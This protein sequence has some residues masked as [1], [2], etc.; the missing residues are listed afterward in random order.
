[1]IREVP[2]SEVCANIYVKFGQSGVFDFINTHYPDVSWKV[3]KPCD[4]ESPVD[5]NSTCLVCGSIV[6]EY[7]DE[8][9]PDERAIKIIESAISHFVAKN[10]SHIPLGVL[11]DILDQLV[12]TNDT[13]FIEPED[14]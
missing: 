9:E 4:S 12:Y 2:L 7:E 3:C 10:Q 14:D 5:D 13:E 1:M 8:A 11:N 6:T